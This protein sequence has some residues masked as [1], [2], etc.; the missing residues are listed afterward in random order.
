MFWLYHASTSVIAVFDP[1]TNT[2][3]QYS[4]YEGKSPNP[5]L[6]GI[7]TMLEDRNGTLWLGT[8]GAG[9]LKFDREGRR[10]IAYR[11]NPVD[12]ESIGQD[13]VISLFED[14][15]GDLGAGLGGWG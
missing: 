8:N 15:E 9:L 14:R 12:P 3:T 7:N 5:V 4:F 11:N 6:T 13:S 1:K 10:F 2:L